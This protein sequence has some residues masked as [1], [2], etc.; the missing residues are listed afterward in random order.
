MIQDFENLKKR[1]GI[2]HLTNELAQ[3]VATDEWAEM[4]RDIFIVHASKDYSSNCVVYI[5]QSPK[6]REL[7]EGVGAPT[8]IFNSEKKEWTEVV[9]K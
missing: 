3:D 5:C 7:G 4:M 8:Y 6:F 9:E 1:R 2:V